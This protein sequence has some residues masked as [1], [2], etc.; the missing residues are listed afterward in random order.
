L[1]KSRAAEDLRQVGWRASRDH[2]FR[3]KSG[4]TSLAACLLLLPAQLASSRLRQRA[5]RSGGSFLA[6]IPIRVGAAHEKISDWP[7]K[8]D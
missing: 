2:Q 3:E 1:A 7:R 8:T 6:E 4:K 5:R